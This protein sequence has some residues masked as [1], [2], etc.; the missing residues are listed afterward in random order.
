[1]FSAF[2]RL[3]GMRYLRARRQEGFISVIA[4]GFGIYPPTTT[5]D[6]AELFDPATGTMR[7]TRWGRSR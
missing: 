5:L 1:M 3:V 4:G 2:E 6:T 7:F